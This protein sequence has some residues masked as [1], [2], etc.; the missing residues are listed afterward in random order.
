MRARK[1]GDSVV[2]VA[3]WLSWAHPVAFFA[4]L[5]VALVLMLALIWMLGRFLRALVR[6]V[7][8]WL[9]S[10]QPAV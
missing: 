5:A 1:A 6:R 10:G 7:S 8:G 9:Q 2:P 4:A 3:L